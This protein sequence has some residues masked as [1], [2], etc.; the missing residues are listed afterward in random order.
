MVVGALVNMDTGSPNTR[1]D[2]G[3]N[4]TAPLFAC[5]TSIRA[6]VMDVTFFMNGTSKFDSLEVRSATPR[7][8]ESNSTIPLWAVEN[9]LGLNVSDVQPIWGLVDNSYEFDPRLWTIRREYMYLPAGS[10]GMTLGSISNSDSLACG[11]PLSIL[12]LLYGLSDLSDDFPDYT[13]KLNLP[14]KRKWQGLS[15]TPTGISNMMGLIWTDM[16]ANYITSARSQLNAMFETPLTNVARAS[17]NIPRS[18]AVEIQTYSR[19]IRYRL[20]YAIAGIIFLALYIIV[21]AAALLMCIT[22]RS[23][24]HLLRTMLNQTSVGRAVTLERYR[25]NGGVAVHVRS[26]TTSKWISE[27]GSEDVGIIKERHKGHGR[28]ASGEGSAQEYQAVEEQTEPT[29][30]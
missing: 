14:L 23:T 6:F 4:W 22:R 21:L 13:G 29:S 19:V 1:F 8:Y 28:K 3:S 26:M 20:P 25:P 24:A 5:S 27:Y 17:L 16:T 18:R 11:G 30:K 7:K 2:P 15:Q 12:D 10:A 9:T